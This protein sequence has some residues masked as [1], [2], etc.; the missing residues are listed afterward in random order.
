MEKPEG[1]AVSVTRGRSTPSGRA[2]S[3]LK[4]DDVVVFG[5]GYAAAGT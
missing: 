1:A 4:L 2:P 3:G 5:H